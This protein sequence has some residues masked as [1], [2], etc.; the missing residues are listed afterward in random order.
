MKTKPNKVP[1]FMA[2]FAGEGVERIGPEDCSWSGDDGYLS[3]DEIDDLV[4]KAFEPQAAIR[5]ILLEIVQSY[6]EDKLRATDADRV[7]K[8][9]QALF[10]DRFQPTTGRKAVEGDG[11]WLQA[12]AEE[13]I[14]DAFSGGDPRSFPELFRAAGRTLDDQFSARAP[15][16]HDRMVRRLRPKFEDNKNLLLVAMS[17]RS[18]D[19]KEFVI[20]REGVQMV[21]RGIRQLKLISV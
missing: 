2:E 4:T 14:R 15:E 1:E 5:Q 12:I 21:R 20:F 10:G 18:N 17:H 8:A 7:E 3:D 11:R 19:C 9:L 13:Y 6:P 16:W